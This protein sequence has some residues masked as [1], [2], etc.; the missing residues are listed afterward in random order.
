MLPEITYVQQG[1][2]H[3]LTIGGVSAPELCL[4][5]GT[6]VYVYARDAFIDAYNRAASA[7][8]RSRLCYALKA[9]GNIH[10]LR[11]LVDAGSGL[12][13]V[14]GGE[15]ERAWLSGTPMNNVV[16]AGVGK[17]SPEIAAALSGKHSLLSPTTRGR[18]GEPAMQ[19][20][21]V[22]LFNIESVQE[23]TRIN[24]I[25][26]EL[27]VRASACLRVNPDVDAKTHKYTTTGKQDNKFGVDIRS[28]RAAAL[29]IAA[30][31][32]IDLVG[33]H[34]HLGSP[35]AT[36]QPYVEALQAAGELLDDFAAHNINISL[37]NIGGGFGIDYGVGEQPLTIAQFGAEIDPHLQ[38]LESSFGVGT[39]IEPGRCIIANS[40]VLLTTVQ[41]IKQARTKRF[42]I[43]DAG[44]H[45]LLRPALYQAHHG[46][47]PAVCADYPRTLRDLNNM[48]GSHTPPAPSDVV[49]PICESSDFL[50]QDRPLPA[51][52]SQ[53]DLLAVFSAGAYGMSMTSTYN[54]HPRPAE[55]MVQ[56]GEHKL[57]RPR[58]NRD[59]LVAS[60]CW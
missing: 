34:I 52:I 11:E 35:I 36:A 5:Y 47:W 54:D 23:A 30:C 6:P 31:T 15:L 49:G 21:P 29:H 3:V 28:A 33:I 20:G 2:T 27:G 40:G 60:E 18:Y 41:Y 12:D 38:S 8:P 56:H 58:Q 39:M 42:L 26:G 14:S 44:M 19:R 45:S 59:E 7:F 22:G 9:C 51:N 57:I 55:V 10:V 37:L 16:F 43:C 50:V 53:G 1:G 46:L 4:A 48:G 25:A 13:V 24:D 32:N 17:T